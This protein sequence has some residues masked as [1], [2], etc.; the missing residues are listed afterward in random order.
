MATCGELVST[1]MPKKS[2]VETWLH[3]CQC[4][5]T[6]GRYCSWGARSDENINSGTIFSFDTVCVGSPVIMLNK[7]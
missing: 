6:S 3:E 7:T 5:V 4:N 2:W 1:R